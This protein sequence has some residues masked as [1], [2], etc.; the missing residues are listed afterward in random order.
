MKTVQHQFVE[1]V[2]EF[3][4]VEEGVLYISIPFATAVHRCMCGCGMEVVTPLSPKDWQIAFNGKAVTLS[5]SIGNSKFKCR[6]HYWIKKGLVIFEKKQ[7]NSRSRITNSN[8]IKGKTS[9]M[10]L[11]VRDLGLLRRKKYGK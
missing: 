10:L 9:Q 8:A 5:P 4:L 11:N 7:I 3:D 6:S 1:Y 2:P